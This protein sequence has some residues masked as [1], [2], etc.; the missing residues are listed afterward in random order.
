M[1]QVV[2]YVPTPHTV[3]RKMLS[4]ASLNQGETLMDLGAGDGRILV[5][6]VREFGSRALGIEL[7]LSRADG[8]S[9]RLKKSRLEQ[10]SQLIPGSFFDAKLPEA[11]VVTMYLLPS[12]N[13]MLRPKLERELKPGTRVISHDFPI[14]GWKPN[15]VQVVDE[16]GHKHFLF[17]YVLPEKSVPAVTNEL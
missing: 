14:W 3:V 5:Q 6:A 4:M 15:D 1:Y 11:D 8:I 7:D 17:L 16:N 9:S 13:W 2:P 12:V 10:E